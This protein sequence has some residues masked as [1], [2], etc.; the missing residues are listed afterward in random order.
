MTNLLKIILVALLISANI[1][2]LSA[3]DIAKIDVNNPEVK[4]TQACDIALTITKITIDESQTRI[5]FVYR[6]NDPYGVNIPRQ[7]HLYLQIKA[8]DGNIYKALATGGMKNYGNNIKADRPEWFSVVFE[9]MP[10]DILAFDLIEAKAIEGVY[11]LPKWNFYDVRIKTE[12]EIRA[13]IKQLK[14]EADGGSANAAYE[15]GMKYEKGK[16]IPQDMD[17]ALEYYL[18]SAQNGNINAKEKIVYAFYLYEYKI[19]TNEVAFGYLVDAANNNSGLCQFL[20]GRAFEDSDMDKAIEWIQKSAENDCHYGQFWIAEK[21]KENKNYE[22]AGY[23]YEKAAKQ[24]NLEAQN[25]LGDLY[26]FGRGTRQDYENAFLRFNE[27]AKGGSSKGKSNLAHMYQYGYGTSQ[28]NEKAIELYED[29][30]K[31]ADDNSLKS[32]SLNGLGNIYQQGNNSI[33]LEKAVSYYQKAIA[34]DNNIYSLYSLGKMHKEGRG[35]LRNPSKAKEYLEKSALG[36]YGAAQ[37]ELALSYKESNN[38]QSAFKWFEKSAQNN[39]PAAQY[40]LG[41]MYYYGK[42]VA[43]NA[44][45]AAVWIE[46]S[47]EAGN[48]DAEKVWNGL[49]LWEYK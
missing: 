31:T 11:K 8:D 27:S 22:S 41:L 47:Y 36:G 2:A 18:K 14:K 16:E 30:I 48:K 17:T 34:L 35:V 46:K 10:F 23:W 7:P 1:C 43:K 21:H 9:K 13:E 26:Y 24:G 28:D 38:L 3:K 20:Y 45:T 4:R 25:E 33:N 15:L 5:D 32:S 19:V 44:K 49:K 40:E 29:I 37:Y 39:D 42:G 6:P 12:A